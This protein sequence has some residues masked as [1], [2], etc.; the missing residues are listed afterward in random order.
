MYAKGKE[1]RFTF[2]AKKRI[3]ERHITEEHIIEVLENPDT[4]TQAR[5]K[6]CRRAERRLG[7]RT[8]GVVYREDRK[9][10]RIITVW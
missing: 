4:E 8:L 9:T 10:I 6:G 2:H 1:L 7:T 5:L 3:L